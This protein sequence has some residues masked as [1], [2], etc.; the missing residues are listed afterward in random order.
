MR[1]VRHNKGLYMKKFKVY[2]VNTKRDAM[3]DRTHPGNQ[4]VDFIKVCKSGLWEVQTEDGKRHSIPKF[5]I[6]VFEVTVRDKVEDAEILD[7]DPWQLH[8]LGIKEERIQ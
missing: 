1:K 6:D 3:M 8:A 4:I 2:H 7:F 5:N